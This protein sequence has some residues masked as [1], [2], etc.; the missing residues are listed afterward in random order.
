MRG[1]RASWLIGGDE[2]AC[3]HARLRLA[4]ARVPKRILLSSGVV[5]VALSPQ[6][7]PFTRVSCLSRGCTR[8]FLSAFLP[9]AYISQLVTR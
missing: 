9:Q 1:F 7:A 2:T 6:Y 8:I 3:F 5:A 4:N